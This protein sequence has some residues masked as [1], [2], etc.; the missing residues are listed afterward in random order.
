VKERN[1]LAAGIAAFTITALAPATASA[2]CPHGDD[3]ASS[4]SSPDQHAALLCAINAERTARGMPG[5]AAAD[6]LASAAQRD[7]QDMVARRFFAHVTP[8]GTTLAERVHATGWM[9]GTSD[10]SLAEAIGWAQE[11][12]DT[13]ATIVQAWLDSPPHRDVLLDPTSD[14]VGI[15][16]A[17]GVPLAPGGGATYV[18]DFG[19]RKV[20]PWRSP[21][22]CA[23][24][25]RRSRRTP[26]RCGSTSTRSRPST[27]VQRRTST[28]SATTWKA[29]RMTS[30]LTS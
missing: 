9:N 19:T 23:R 24:E 14:E 28:P 11:P 20:R 27:R 26:A 5:A 18:V 29:R 25:A 17:P 3:V 4:L 21:T 13:T 7:A 15:G 6:Q 2:A 12:L 22:T 30:G 10:W 8:E 16:V 1:A